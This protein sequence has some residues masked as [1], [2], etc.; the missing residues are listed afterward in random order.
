MKIRFLVA[1]LTAL[2]AGC[3]PQ[4]LPLNIHRLSTREAIARSSVVAVGMVRAI[5]IFGDSRRTDEGIW[6]RTW[7]VEVK[8]LC[9]LK[10]TIEGKN[11]TFL[12]NNYDP[13]VG[14]QNGDFEWLQTG[15]RRVF[16]L[17]AQGPMLRCVSDLY[18]TSLSFPHAGLPPVLPSTGEPIGNRIAMLLLGKANGESPEDFAKMIPRATREALRSSGYPFVASLLRQLAASELLEVRTEACLT[19]YEQTFGGE[20]CILQLASGNMTPEVS[21]RISKAREHRAYLRQLADR[22]LREGQECPLLYYTYA[23]EPGDP[24]SVADFL[25]L[26]AQQPDPIFRASAERQLRHLSA[27]LAR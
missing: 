23:V 27:P 13:R 11:F 21:Q 25:T 15:D 19:A 8:P 5:S 22:A 3:S 20:T 2:L 12:F 6:V 4:T 18:E 17:A 10:G 14:V 7:R 24:T 16:F 9:V 1:T 26:L